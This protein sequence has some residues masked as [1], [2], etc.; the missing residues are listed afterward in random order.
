MYICFVTEIC[1]SM[2]FLSF[3]MCMLCKYIYLLFIIYLSVSHLSI[4]S[5][6]LFSHF[7]P[8]P[9]KASLPSATYP[10]T[11]TVIR[12]NDCTLICYN[13]PTCHSLYQILLLTLIPW[14]GQV[15]CQ[16]YIIPYDNCITTAVKILCYT[17]S[18]SLPISLS[19]AD[20]FVS[21][22]ATSEM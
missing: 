13:H 2:W 4:F 6:S 18:N 15:Q 5:L 20:A 9:T 10:Y 1:I 12:V 17:H 11:G 21:A 7:P 14:L 3:N 8:V 19:N 16:V 22:V